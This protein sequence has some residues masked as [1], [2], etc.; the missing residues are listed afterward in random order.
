MARP[1]RRHVEFAVYLQDVGSGAVLALT[2]DL[3]DHT[4]PDRPQRS[5]ADRALT[6]AV[7][8]ASFLAVGSGQLLINR[9]R[10]TAGFELQL[11]RGVG[12]A[13]VTPQTFTWE[14]LQPPLLALSF[15]EL[16]AR[17]ASLPPACLRPRRVAEDFHVCAVAGVA[18]VRF[19]HSTQTVEAVLRDRDG[20]QALLSHP[21]TTRG[22]AGAEALLQRLASPESLRF[23]SGTVR[24]TVADLVLHP[25]CVVWETAGRRGALQPWIER[26]AEGHEKQSD[27]GGEQEDAGEPG[28]ALAHYLEALRSAVGE[29]LLLG[30]SRA[31]T[32]VARRWA[33]LVKR[34]ES[35]GFTR[36]AG[37]LRRLAELLEQK[38]HTLTWDVRGAARALLEVTVLVRLTQDVAC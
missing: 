19:N 35:L 25:A 12:Q 38:A 28:D 36:L 15:R 23:V 17:F 7:K 21:Y 30:L 33:E 34:G 2:K 16:S 22:R 13:S 11:I 26:A 1:G 32:L 5:Y 31:D 8:G 3:P 9:G 6:H 20:N 29:L 27:A 4:E 14:E 10:R 24:R 18:G 37:R